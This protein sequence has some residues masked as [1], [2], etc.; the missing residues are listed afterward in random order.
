MAVRFPSS[1]SN[2]VQIPMSDISIEACLQVE[3]N[4]FRL[5]LAAARRARQLAEG[6][7]PLVHDD[8]SKATMLALAEIQEGENSIENILS[9]HNY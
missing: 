2:E 9:R 4:R 3:N 1:F 6:H 7:H 8:G 5:V